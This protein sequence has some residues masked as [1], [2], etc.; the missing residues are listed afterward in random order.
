MIVRQQSVM[1]I[2]VIL[3]YVV[4]FEN[5]A[6]IV[7]VNT[8]V[9]TVVACLSS[10]ALGYRQEWFLPTRVVLATFFI[11]IELLVYCAGDGQCWIEA[12]TFSGD[13]T[14]GL[15]A[16]SVITVFLV[17]RVTIAQRRIRRLRV[18]GCPQPTFS[19][20]DLR[21]RSDFVLPLTEVRQACNG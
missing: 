13:G 12:F 1:W 8:V 5:I 3:L 16:G 6:T 4:A 10:V 19:V 21:V 7:F 17:T 15:P 14:N 18:K 11:C 20:R 2:V 9:N